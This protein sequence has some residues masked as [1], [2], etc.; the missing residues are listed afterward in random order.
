MHLFTQNVKCQFSDETILVSDLLKL[1]DKNDQHHSVL[2]KCLNIEK[3]K[4]DRINIPGSKDLLVIQNAINNNYKKIDI[5]SS[6]QNIDLDLDDKNVAFQFKKLESNSYFD[7]DQEQC[8]KVRPK[9]SSQS[10]FFDNLCNMNKY[11]NELINKGLSD[12]LIYNIDAI[13]KEC[14]KLRIYRV[15]HDLNE[16]EFY[17]RAIVST[18]Y[19]NYDNNITIVIALI[20][21]HNRMKELGIKYLLNRVEYNESFIRIYFEEEKQT[22]LDGI[23]SVKNLI[24]VSNDE[25]KRE[26]LKFYAINSIEFYDTQDGTPYEIIIQ[27]SHSSR[28]KIKSEILSMSHS[29]SAKKFVERIGEID[30]LNDL[31]KDLLLNIQEVSKISNLLEIRIKVLE[32]IDNSR[33]S[34]FKKY[35]SEAMQ[36]L[37]SQEVS[38][39]TQLLTVFNKLSLLT[40][41]DIEATDYVRYVIYESLIERRSR[42]IN[43]VE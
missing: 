31:N 36:I 24:E 15:L 43:S 23:G 20:T 40:D 8:I 38:T 12:L 10:D 11:A 9:Y 22:K 16:N 6:L 26:A 13:K 29:L 7:S 1:L 37:E 33:N 27:P 30:S 32:M 17:L 4:G 2:E 34:S 3:I 41:S 35:K 19:N 42:N 39:F 14:D 21:L 28:S 25:I 18:Q 5:E